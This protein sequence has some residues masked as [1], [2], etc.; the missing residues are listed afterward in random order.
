MS[1]RGRTRIFPPEPGQTGRVSDSSTSDP[2]RSGLSWGRGWWTSTPSYL[3][4]HSGPDR[5]VGLG[6]GTPEAPGVPGV[7]SGGLLAPCRAPQ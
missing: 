6:L 4:T 5:G 7:S 1:P 2:G 3:D